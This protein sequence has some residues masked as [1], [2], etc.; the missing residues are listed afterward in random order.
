MKKILLIT[1]LI[2]ALL[3]TVASCGNE[4]TPTDTEPSATVAATVAETIPETVPQ[5]DPETEAETE[6]PETEAPE[7]EEETQPAASEETK[8][9]TE[10]E[11]ERVLPADLFPVGYSYSGNLTCFDGSYDFGF[12]VARSE[13]GKYFTSVQ[14]CI[15]Y[16]ETLG[17][18]RMTID[19]PLD[20]CL[21]LN[22]P[23][24]G[25]TYIIY[26]NFVN[27][28]FIF[29]HGVIYDD[30][31]LDTAVVGIPGFAYYSDL[32]VLDAIAG[33][34]NTSIWVCSEDLEGFEKARY[35]MTAK[36]DGD[37]MNY[38]YERIADMD[39]W[40]GLIEGEYLPEE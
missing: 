6:A 12:D 32:S 14:A 24:D 39:T 18:G 7:T 34:E 10:E 17:G 13:D 27:C 35:S 29:D 26:Y 40:Y 20:I 16:L 9:E 2:S 19:F 37:K 36:Q 31:V 38:H 21:Y 1:A 15:D 30:S 11:T 5:T 22:I 25:N 28:D 8:E 3:M 23:D 33:L 4:N